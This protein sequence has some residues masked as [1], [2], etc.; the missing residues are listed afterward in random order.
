MNIQERSATQEPTTDRTSPDQAAAHYPAEL[1][2]LTVQLEKARALEAE[3]R[4]FADSVRDYAFITMGLD[5]NVIGWNKG[6]ELLL[7]YS[8]K[9]MLGRPGALLFTPEDVER[10]EPDN[11]ISTALR[12]GRAEDERWHLRKDGTRFWGSGVL[13]PLRNAFGEVRGYAKVMRDRTEARE[14]EQAVRIREERLR[15]LLENI[16]D[17]AVFDLSKSQEICSW[18]SGAEQIFGYAASEVLGVDAGEFFGAAGFSTESFRQ[19][20]QV[21]LSSGRGEG[22]SWLT[23]KDGTCFFARWITNAIYS[24]DAQVVGFIKVLRD[25][26]M[27]RKTEDEEARRKQFAW[28]WIEEQARAASSALGKTQAELVEIGRR[29][30]GVQ[31]EERRRIARDLHDHLAQRL[32]LLELGLNR[33]RDGLPGDF[34]VL[35]TQV[36]GLQNHTAA[37]AQD[38]REISHRLHPSILEHLGLIPA[39]KGLCDQYQRSRMASV[40]FEPVQDGSPIPVEVATAFYRICEEALRNIQKHAGDV[41]AVVQMRAENSELLLR[42]HDAGPG[43]DPDAVE[44]GRHLG[45]ISMRERATMVGAICRCISQPGKG[46]TIEVRLNRSN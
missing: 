40:I 29:L 26:T 30:L 23:R 19:E 31:E 34:E 21:A 37:L 43:F 20:L 5:A 32:A 35:Q 25:E 15:L 22:E 46:T 12:E 33:L 14:F 6:A 45:L 41:P 28:D 44:S 16:R 18:N 11:E 2:D 9:E 4:A 1:E 8:P 7:G 10:G 24:D 27:R 36:A 3:F 42:I 17:C 13:T 38:V 39:L